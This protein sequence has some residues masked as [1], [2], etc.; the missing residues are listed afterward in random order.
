MLKIK[1]NEVSTGTKTYS[2]VQVA[3]G[4]HITPVLRWMLVGLLETTMVVLNDGIEQISKHRVSLRVWRIDANSRV[5]VLKT[6][7][8]QIGQNIRLYISI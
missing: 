7:K 5:M 1:Y 2:R 4:V 6:C 8:T 3:Q